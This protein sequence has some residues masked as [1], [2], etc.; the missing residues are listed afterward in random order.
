MMEA[1]HPE[2]APLRRPGE[3]G[4][5]EPGIASQGYSSPEPE[6]APVW[7]SSPIA[8][9]QLTLSYRE[10][11]G[12][13]ETLERKTA[14]FEWLDV[15]FCPKSTLDTARYFV[16]QRHIALPTMH[17]TGR[18]LQS[19]RI[20]LFTRESCGLC[21]QARSVL[22][23]VWDRRPFAFKEIDIIKPES[24]AWRDLYEFDVPV[25]SSAPAFPVTHFLPPI[26]KP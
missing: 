16:T 13:S 22:S 19:C 15:F 14:W 26:L 24:K 11:S 17:V 4:G 20:T 10:S 23:D 8:D 12:R 9:R 6:L 25:V 18:L 21:T 5:G 1:S 2:K 3:G 7:P